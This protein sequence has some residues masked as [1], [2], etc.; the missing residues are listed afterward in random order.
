MNHNSLKPTDREIII[1]GLQLPPLTDKGYDRPS[2]MA[3]AVKYEL[4]DEMD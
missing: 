4:T 2:Q 3:Q 1:C